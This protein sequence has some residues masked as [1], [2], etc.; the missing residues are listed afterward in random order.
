MQYHLDHIGTFTSELTKHPTLKPQ[1]PGLASKKFRHAY[2]VSDGGGSPR[3]SAPVLGRSNVGTRASPN[4]IGRIG[5]TG[6][7]CARGRAHSDNVVVPPSLTQ[8][9]VR[10]TNSSHHDRMV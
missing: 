8:Y 6:A 9:I 7:R 1:N 4:G 3:R 5:T 2:S 10:K